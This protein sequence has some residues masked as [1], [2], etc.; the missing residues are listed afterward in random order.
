LKT[1]EFEH[2]LDTIPR[3][4]AVLR[5]IKLYPWMEEHVK[6]GDEL[7]AYADDDTV[8][9]RGIKGG[10]LSIKPSCL[11]FLRFEEYTLDEV[12]YGKTTGV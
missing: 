6:K 10:G 5:V 8:Y 2:L 3:Y 4:R 1:Q 9:R 11:K 7:V 12:R